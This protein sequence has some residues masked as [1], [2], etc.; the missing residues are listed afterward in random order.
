MTVR[1][2]VQGQAL[3]L[4]RQFLG[5]VVVLLI[6]G[7]FLLRATLATVPDVEDRTNWQMVW[8]M[9]IIMLPVD[10]CA[11]FWVGLWQALAAKNPNHAASGSVWR[12]MVAPSLGFAFVFLLRVLLSEHNNPDVG[13]KFF[14]SWWMGLGLA[15]DFL[16]AWTARRKLLAAFR[17]LAAQRYV[18]RAGF[19]RRLMGAT[20][21][22]D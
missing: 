10:L 1:E 14:V 16:F 5:P 21:S 19:W 2:I 12:I 18:R 20:A 13:W 17:T 6:V 4:R 3:A 22:S 15:A 11:F 8:L 9:G 7:L